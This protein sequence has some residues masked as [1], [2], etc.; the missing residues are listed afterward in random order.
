[1]AKV[2]GVGGVFF[3]CRDKAALGAWYQEHLGMQINEYGGME[4]EFKSAPKGGYCVWGPFSDETDY[5]SPSTKPFMINLIVDN[6]EAVLKKAQE[7][8][9][10]LVGEIEESQYGRFGWFLDPENNKVEL[11]QPN[12]DFQ[13]AK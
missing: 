1:M 5:F 2:L 13:F 10:T 11:W 9:A 3:K 8:G 12:P 4:F 6:L 7:G